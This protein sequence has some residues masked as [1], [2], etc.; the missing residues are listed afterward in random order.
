MCRNTSDEET[1]NKQVQQFKERLRKR[2]YQKEEYDQVINKI[3]YR[4][5]PKYIV[6][7]TKKDKHNI[8]PFVIPY[9]H[10]THKVTQKV[11]KY[12]DIISHNEELNKIFPKKPMI[13]YKRAQNLGDTLMSAK[14]KE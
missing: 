11:R 3:S 10:E 13:S 7:Q 5:R 12:W 4:D 1:Y 9:S 2:G 14:L 6:Q 8:L